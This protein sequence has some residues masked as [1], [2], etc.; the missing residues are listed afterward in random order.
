MVE[1]RSEEFEDAMAAVK[2]KIGNR[3]WGEMTAVEKQR[4][5]LTYSQNKIKNC[6]G[7]GVGYVFEGNIIEKLSLNS[8]NNTII[9]S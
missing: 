7:W 6:E 8:A 9:D 1:N 3:M 5:T 2:V 4:E